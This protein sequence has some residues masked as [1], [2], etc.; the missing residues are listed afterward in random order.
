MNNVLVTVLSLSVSGTILGLLLITVR[1]LF[2]HSVPKHFLY[3]MWVLVLLRLIVPIS[4]PINITEFAVRQVFPGVVVQEDSSVSVSPETDIT[5]AGEVDVVPLADAR[6][7]GIVPNDSVVDEASTSR[8]PTRMQDLWSLIINNMVG[9]WAAGA[10][11]SLTWFIISYLRFVRQINRTGVPPHREDLAVFHTL[12]PDKHVRLICSRHIATP[13]L[14]G[15]M[16]PCIVIPQLAY[17]QNG[18]K[19]SLEN[20]LRHELMH[21][22]RKDLIFKW[23]VVFVSSMHWFNPFIILLRREINRACELACD[24]AVIKGLTPQQRMRYGETLLDLAGE[25]RLPASL[26]ATTLCEG[27][28]QLIERILSIKKY[29]KQ[30]AWMAALAI[31]LTAGLTGCG[32]ML[33]SAAE[34]LDGGNT[35][36]QSLNTGNTDIPKSTGIPSQAGSPAPS[37]SATPIV[38][39]SPEPITIPSRTEA[40]Q[41]LV[42]NSDFELAGFTL[43]EG[44]QTELPTLYAWQYSVR[45]LELETLIDEGNNAVTRIWEGQN[46]TYEADD[47][48]ASWTANLLDTEYGPFKETIRVSSRRSSLVYTAMWTQYETTPFHYGEPTTKTVQELIDAAKE[49]TD[50]LLGTEEYT[51]GVPTVYETK[52]G[53]GEIDDGVPAAQ[54]LRITWRYRC[55][56]LAVGED[57][58]AVTLINGEV[59]S[60]SFK[61]HAVTREDMV[62]PRLVLNAEEALYCINYTRSYHSDENDVFYEAFAL[63]SVTPVLINIFSDDENAYTPAWEF[64]ILCDENEPAEMICYVDAATG[65]VYEG[66]NKGGLFPSAL[67]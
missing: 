42:M 5:P 50:I 41:W 59:E 39:T 67:D 56:G 1:W 52:R 38:L 31:I 36:G 60:L 24:E 65:Q 29:K 16:R 35:K 47:N 64:R 44:T 34:L 15:V 62:V 4:A 25:R 58:A 21:E 33:G 55:D 13:L 23:L 54:T 22:Q 51:Q 14:M 57:G 63:E 26:P 10:C 30:T 19:T 9:I 11:A 43:P 8:N 49:F 6:E 7:A 61:R 48:S 18:M 45:T 2:K 53:T 28:N 46:V 3:Y 17:T 27:K 20:T 32:A 40:L 12:C 37:A 66:S